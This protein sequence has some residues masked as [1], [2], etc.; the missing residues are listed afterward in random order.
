MEIANLKYT[1]MQIL[2][3]STTSFN[4]HATGKHYLMFI[5]RLDVGKVLILHLFF[6]LPYSTFLSYQ[7]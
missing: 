1:Y 7:K 5:F 6:Y 4:V 2:F 3:K